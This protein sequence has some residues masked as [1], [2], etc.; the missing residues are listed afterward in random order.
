MSADSSLS[1]ELWQALTVSLGG[2]AVFLGGSAA[3]GRPPPASSEHLGPYPMPAVVA[4]GDRFP[5]LP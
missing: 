4:A 5:L 3:P 1:A 2:S